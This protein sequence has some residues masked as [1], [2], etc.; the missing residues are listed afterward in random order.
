ME[1]PQKKIFEQRL[2]QL[3]Y[4]C[5]LRFY[6]VILY[7]VL[8]EKQALDQKCSVPLCQAWLTADEA[9]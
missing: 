3:L 1:T 8:Y 2:T 4:M 5:T 7:P 9:P 6:T